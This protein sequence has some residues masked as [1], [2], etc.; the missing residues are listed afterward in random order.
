[1]V[2]SGVL[3]EEDYN[4]NSSFKLNQ[5]VSEENVYYCPNTD[6]KCCFILEEGEIHN[7]ITGEIDNE[8]NVMNLE[9]IQHRDKY[10]VRCIKCEYI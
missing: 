5:L 1:M 2:T 3:E 6:C 7:E 8:G 4:K 9:A 10:R